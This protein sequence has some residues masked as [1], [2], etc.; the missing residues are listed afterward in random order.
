MLDPIGKRV[1]ILVE[2]LPCPFDRRVWQEATAL[3]DAGYRPGPWIDETPELRRAIDVIASGALDGGSGLFRP[4]VDTLTGDDRYQL[5]ADFAA[6]ADCQRRAAAVYARPDE[7]W[8]LSIL[9][10][11]GMGK[12]SS[13]RTTREYAEEIWDVKPV[14]VA[15]PV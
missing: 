13:D 3:R 6:Y 4:I 14:P 8:R 7:W 10:V 1:L 12:F 11:A 5:C 15:P 9:N 2:N